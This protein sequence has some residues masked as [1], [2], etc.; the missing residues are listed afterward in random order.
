MAGLKKKFYGNMNKFSKLIFEKRDLFDSHLK[1]LSGR[2]VITVE[3]YIPKRSNQQ[4]AYWHGVIVKLL[5]DELGY[6]PDE[7]HTALKMEFLRVR[8][9]GKPDTV[10]STTKLS[11]KDFNELKESVQIWAKTEFNVYIPDPYEVDY[12]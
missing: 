10:G 7:M 8:R 2:V 9:D 6:T 5:A 3:K 4:N 12:D 1:K 11:T